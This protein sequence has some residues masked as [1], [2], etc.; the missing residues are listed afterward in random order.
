MVSKKIT[1]M[2][3]EGLHIRPAG[4]LCKEALKFESRFILYLI[5]KMQMQKV[6]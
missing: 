5:I 2:N 4:V 6:Y 3:E 1:V